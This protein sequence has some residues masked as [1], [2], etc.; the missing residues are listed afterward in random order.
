[1][2]NT[3]STSSRQS[4]PIKKKGRTRGS[5][6]VQSSAYESVG[7]FNKDGV[8]PISRVRKNVEGPE[9]LLKSDKNNVS[10]VGRLYLCKKDNGLAISTEST[11]HFCLVLD[12]GGHSDETNLR[13]ACMH[14]SF[15]KDRD[16]NLVYI[17]KPINVEK[18][19]CFNSVTDTGGL[20]YP[21]DNIEHIKALSMGHPE[22][23]EMDMSA[24][25][26]DLWYFYIVFQMD[27]WL[28]E[29]VEIH[30][31]KMSA[32][33]NCQSFAKF[34]HKKLSGVEFPCGAIF[35]Q[36]T[37]DKLTYTAYSCIESSIMKK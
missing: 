30:G 21:H 15:T 25:K 33:C 36:S 19:K 11:D 8:F 6:F 12:I 17:Q 37:I 29:F 24:D 32:Y 26:N 13:G 2:G 14:V 18:E 27:D 31:N 16:K 3:T 22:Y 28:T 35:G 7:I 4:L 34:L 1:M 10:K 20:V 5:S 23:A 9:A